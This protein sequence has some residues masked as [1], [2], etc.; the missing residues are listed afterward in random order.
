MLKALIVEGDVDLCGLFSRIL[1]TAGYEVDCFY[2]IESAL[3]E[4]D[5]TDYDL[6][7][8]DASIQ[9]ITKK[10]VNMLDKSNAK[11]CLTSVFTEKKVEEK[12]KDLEY[13]W[14]IQKPFTLSD[15]TDVLD[16]M[17]Q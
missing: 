17:D 14:F 16:T 3:E 2:Q 7:I 9:E 12:T 11:I 6:V 5:C 8:L 13:D 15:W 10:A 1:S 4:I